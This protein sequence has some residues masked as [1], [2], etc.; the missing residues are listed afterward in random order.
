[1]HSHDRTLIAKLGFADPDKKDPRHDLA[2]QFLA[3]PE[4]AAKL[5]ALFRGRPAVYHPDLIAKYG[6]PYVPR[7]EVPIFKGEGQYRVT[8]GFIDVRIC[9]HLPHFCSDERCCKPKPVDEWQSY[10]RTA[11]M[12]EVKIARMSVNEILRQILFYRDSWTQSRDDIYGH[13]EDTR[14]AIATPWPVDVIEKEL[15]NT[16]RI[17]HIRL[18]DGFE[19]F[20]AEV[21]Q[22]R[23][24][25]SDAEF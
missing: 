16:E 13:I 17:R 9:I 23:A 1:M 24:S 12:I 6:D 18:G 22:R 14:W 2:C 5:A 4:N 7:V 21:K 25:A 19:K 3:L 8:V 10:N 15:L 11:L 20:L